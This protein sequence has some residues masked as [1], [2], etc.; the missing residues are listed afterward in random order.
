MTAN[1]ADR[2]Q[3]LKEIFSAAIEVSADER[4]GYVLR[5]CGGDEELL[6]QARRLLAIHQESSLALDHPVV[7]GTLLDAVSMPEELAAG[8]FR[9]VR[10]LGAG[11]MGEVYEAEDKALNLRLALKTIRGEHARQPAYLERLREEI[12]LLR[13]VTHPNVCRVFDFFPGDATQPTFFTMELVEGE[14][15]AARLERAGALGEKEADELFRQVLDALSAA[16]AQ[17]IIHRDLKPAN[18]MLG[19]NA[20]GGL[21]AVLMDFG[22]AQAPAKES[23]RATGETAP[24]GTPAYMSPEQLEACALTPASDLYSFGLVACEAATGKPLFMGATALA[25]VARKLTTPAASLVRPLP[26][27]WRKVILRCL[28]TNPEARYQTVAEVRHALFARRSRRWPYTAAAVLIIALVVVEWARK[29]PAEEALRVYEEGVVALGD[30]ATV[31]A[32]GLFEKAI[33]RSPGFALAHARKA[34]AHALLDAPDLAREAMLRAM[35]ARRSAWLPAARDRRV[36]D[37]IRALVTRDFQAA[38]ERFEAAEA[39][40]DA[41]AARELSEQPDMA[42]QHYLRVIEKDAGNATAHLRLATLAARRQDTAAALTAL[43]QAQQA[44]E[45]PG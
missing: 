5:A 3:A 44:Y 8:R 40:L 27:R 15:L 31:R 36:F 21:R 2:W 30:T 42:R 29:R 17:G 43:E 13:E 4:D 34:Q 16:H 19:R 41:G 7:P 45:R 39:L 18:I 22:V 32:L 11:G 25:I 6:A 24:V 35:E 12:R 26:R 37:A 23:T 38:A 20:D 28:A 1:E 10:Q 9:I 33:E 14:S